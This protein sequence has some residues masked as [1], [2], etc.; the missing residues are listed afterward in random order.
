MP[1]HGGVLPF[2]LEEI[3]PFDM[4][5]TPDTG[6]LYDGEGAPVETSDTFSRLYG[7]GASLLS[8]GGSTLCIQTMLALF[9]GEGQKVI[10]SRNAHHSAVN[11]MGLL[12]LSPVWLYGERASGV[13]TP[14]R[15]TAEEVENALREHPDAAAVYITSPSYFGTLSDI[16]DIAET[17]HRRNKPLLVDNAHGAHLI[18]FEN[19]HPMALGADACCDSLHKTLPALTG[20]A[21]LHLRDCEKKEQA[22]RCM[23]LF[24]STSPSYITMLSADMLCGERY[25][26]ETLRAGFHALAEKAEK[27][28]ALAVKKGV[29]AIDADKSLND[30]I[31]IPLL[32]PENWR[33]QALLALK[34]CG[35]EAEYVSARHIVLLPNLQSE[36]QAAEDLISMLPALSEKTGLP[37]P[38]K[39]ET[40]CSIREAILSEAQ[41]L[42]V[43]G[44][45]GRVC[46]ESLAP[47]PPGSALLIPGER[48][49]GEIVPELINAGIE[50]VFVKKQP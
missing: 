12:G 34:Q 36:L 32:F 23:K 14:G 21:L 20:A 44:C 28:R 1:G 29:S 49:S 24:G 10:M 9:C 13:L 45:L 25:F 2:P 11:A 40:A 31:R 35:I 22:R 46:C 26:N 6:C 18:F 15:I 39:A 33:E 17:A 41:L 43:Q 7:S 30:P 48:I 27:I 19:M 4:T 50:Q 38:L 37:K 8:T 47:C 5:E 3:A 42:P 16:R